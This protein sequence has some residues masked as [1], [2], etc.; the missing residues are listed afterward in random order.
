MQ[1]IRCES[2]ILPCSTKGEGA[3]MFEWL[4]DYVTC[5]YEDRAPEPVQQG[6][7][8]KI[9]MSMKTYCSSMF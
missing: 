3:D 4:I 8:D 1:I 7:R 5:R 9:Y 6:E 2:Q